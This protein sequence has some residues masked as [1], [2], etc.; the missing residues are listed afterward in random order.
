MKGFVVSL[1]IVLATVSVYAGGVVCDHDLT[2]DGGGCA[3]VTGGSFEQGGW[4]GSNGG[5]VL[6]TSPQPIDK[7]WAEVSF[8]VD[9]ISTDLQNK[10][11]CIF[12]AIYDCAAISQHSC[13]MKAYVRIRK[14]SE[15]PYYIEFKARD[16]NQLHG[17]GE[18]RLYNRDDWKN[19][20]GKEVH[21]KL[22][23]GPDMVITLEYPE[24]DGSGYKTVTRGNYNITNI[25]Y[26]VVGAEGSYDCSFTGF[27]YTRL[28]VYDHEATGS[29]P[30]VGQGM[31]LSSPTPA[32]CY[33]IAG[34]QVFF[35]LRNNESASIYDLKGNMVRVITPAMSALPTSDFSSGRYMLTVSSPTTTSRVPLLIK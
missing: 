34:D 3:T 13:A 9:D 30:V 12:F 14:E 28:Q 8:I 6:Y 32:S 35:D 26:V 5:R 29:T 33:R 22:M 25:K 11:K 16:V 27:R 24:Q 4:V 21:L 15:R 23:W 31:P 20:Y 19:Y 7:G 17:E 2:Q 10:R 18:T 1:V